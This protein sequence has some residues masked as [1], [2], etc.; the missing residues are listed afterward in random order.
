MCRLIPG[1]ATVAVLVFATTAMGQ[2]ES[3]TYQGQL[4]QQGSPLT[5]LVDMRFALYDAE[6]AEQPIAGPLVFDGQAFSPV[7]VTSGQTV[8]PSCRSPR[9][10]SKAA[11]G[12]RCRC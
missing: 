4:K 9:A 2:A 6:S 10:M 1:V 8:I 12:I 11:S 7:Q 3:F 5:D